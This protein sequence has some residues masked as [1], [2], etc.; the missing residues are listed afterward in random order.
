M[1][2]LLVLD[3]ETG[4]LDSHIQSILSVGGV[5]INEKLDVVSEFE[6]YVK[7]EDII[8]EPR[9][10]AINKIDLHWLRA[11]GRSP[12]DTVMEMRKFFDKHFKPGEKIPLVGHNIEFDVNFVKRLYRKAGQGLL[13]YEETFSHRTLDTAGIIRFLSLAGRIALTSSAADNAFKHYGIE[14]SD[15]D[16]HTALGDAKATAT[17]LKNLVEEISIKT[18]VGV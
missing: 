17:L 18:F 6:I 14:I 9:A 10:L 16:R 13:G 4:G 1:D 12:I 5:V 7:E 11:N 3:T 2:N 8:A 15:Q